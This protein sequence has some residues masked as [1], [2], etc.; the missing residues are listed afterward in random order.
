MINNQITQTG[1][2]GVIGPSKTK[3]TSSPMEGKFLKDYVALIVVQ[4]STFF[5]KVKQ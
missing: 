3:G 5:Q 1:C 2:G 4:V